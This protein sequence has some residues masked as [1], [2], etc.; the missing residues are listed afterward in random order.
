V[1]RQ[2]QPWLIQPPGLVFSDP[3]TPFLR[4]SSPAAP[5]A[6][7]AQN[8]APTFVR[9]DASTYPDEIVG[10]I[11]VDAY[12]ERFETLLT[13]AQWQALVRLNVRIGWD[14]VQPVPGYGDIETT[15]FGK[16]N[17]AMRQA[18]ATTPLRPMPLAVLAHARPFGVPESEELPSN[19]LES[20]MCAGYEDLVT[21]VPNGRFFVAEN[22]GHDIHQGQPELVT[23]AIRQVV[24]GVRNRD[25]WYDLTS[26]CASK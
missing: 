2:W 19:T 9:L 1:S 5:D 17:A 6:L 15:G 25:T 21:L 26:C 22:S 3:S 23:E 14:T 8:R 7:L 24:A 16:D 20:V 13:P 11:L 4:R 10:L 12:S 18:A